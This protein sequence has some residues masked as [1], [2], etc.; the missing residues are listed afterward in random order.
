[1]INPDEFIFINGKFKKK[2]KIT[3]SPFDRGLLLG[4]GFFETLRV[5][6]GKPFAFTI[7]M[8]RLF[9]SLKT[10]NIHIPESPDYLKRACMEL[11]ERNLKKNTA[12]R[13]TITRG[14]TDGR[15]GLPKAGTPLR[16]IYCRPLNLPGPKAYS[17][18]VPAI[19]AKTQFG[20]SPSMFGHKTTGYLENLLAKE[21][22]FKRGAFEALLVD[23]AG[24]I[25][26]GATSNVFLIH[27]GKVM[28]PP[29]SRGPL[30]G[31][32]R[33]LCLEIMKKNDM[34]FKEEEITLSAL[35]ECQGAFIT[36][37]ILEILPI[38][39]IDGAEVGVG[40]PHPISILLAKKYRKLVNNE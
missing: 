35:K 38:T 9:N 2:K 29:L 10:F 11:C 23:R 7:H 33:K 4:D 13:I 19:I 26:E 14:E 6:N 31:I 34:V 1:M 39:I 20:K 36:N 32:T 5:Y 25:I 16:M 12:I 30:P 22:A 37:S 15:L 27:D 18:G 40:N 17:D 8:E 3:I 21:E 28:T 24:D